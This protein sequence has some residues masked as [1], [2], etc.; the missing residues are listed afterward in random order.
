MEI[1]N[2][3]VRDLLRPAS[4]KQLH[5][6]RV[7]EHPTEGPYVESKCPLCV[8]LCVCVSVSM[9]VF[10]CVCVCVCVSVCVC[11][12]LCVCLCVCVSVCVSVSVCLYVCMYVYV[13]LYSIALNYDWSCTNAGSHFVARAKGTNNKIK[14]TYGIVLCL[15]SA[16][17]KIHCRYHRL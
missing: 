12:C 4:S 10:V 16:S 3:R 7:R 2:E 14:C 5:N 1:Y 9:S 17:L 15:S 11:V 13:C 6:L 8:C